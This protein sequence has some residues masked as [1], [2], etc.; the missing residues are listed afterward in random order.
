MLAL[1]LNHD[2]EEGLR[3]PDWMEDRRWS[4]F[5]GSGGGWAGPM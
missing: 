2:I 4:P 5:A 3:L 1:G